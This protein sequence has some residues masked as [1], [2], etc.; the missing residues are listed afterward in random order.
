MALDHRFSKR[1]Y[2]GQEYSRRDIEASFEFIPPPPAPSQLD[3][4]DSDEELARA[5]GYW[6]PSQSLALSA[7]Y[8]YEDIDRDDDYP[9]DLVAGTPFTELET[10]RVPLGVTIHRPSGW[11]AGLKATYVDQEG[12]FPDPFSLSAVTD[13]DD[14]WIVDTGVGY[15]LPKRHGLLSVGVKNLFDE[16][17]KFQDTNPISPTFYPE[18]LVFGRI[19]LSF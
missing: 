4:A 11:F 10:H 14:F 2:G 13:H 19:T 9:P 12:T 8:Q 5:Y 1:L 18:R 7:E 16:S 6:T 17:F 3:N 15:R